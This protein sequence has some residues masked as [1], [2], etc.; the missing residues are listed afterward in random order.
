MMPLETEDLTFSSFFYPH[1]C[2]LR[3]PRGKEKIMHMM[4]FSGQTWRSHCSGRGITN[5]WHSAERGKLLTQF[6]SG[7]FFVFFKLITDIFL[8]AIFVCRM[9]FKE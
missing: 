5:K 2:G 1:L 8:G 4:Y 9:P 3:E 7:F 6:L